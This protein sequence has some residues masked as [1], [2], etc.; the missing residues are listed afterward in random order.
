[1]CSNTCYKALEFLMMHLSMILQC[2]ENAEPSYS[3]WI[4]ILPLNIEMNTKDG[5]VIILILLTMLL[6][7]YSSYKYKWTG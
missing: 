1:M 5:G 4:F 6:N 2:L 7:D 3:I